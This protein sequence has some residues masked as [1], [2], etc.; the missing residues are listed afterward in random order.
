M[1]VNVGYYVTPSLSVR[2]GYSLL[3]LTD[4][5]R[6]GDQIDTAIGDSGVPGA[7]PHPQ[8]DMDGTSVCLQGVSLGAEW[9][10]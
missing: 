1:G 9:R 3:W 2:A 6:T 7:V 4:A 10:R 8:A 5:L